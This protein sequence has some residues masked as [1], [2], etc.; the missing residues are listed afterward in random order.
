MVVNQLEKVSQSKTR[1]GVI[2]GIILIGT[3][4]M[5]QEGVIA[6]MMGIYGATALVLSVIARIALIRLQRTD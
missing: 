6:G 5:L 1:M 3:G 4:M 2:L